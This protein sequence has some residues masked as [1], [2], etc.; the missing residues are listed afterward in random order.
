MMLAR[1]SEN[2]GSFLFLCLLGFVRLRVV[3]SL[4]LVDFLSQEG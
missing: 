3:C 2:V 1:S 4:P